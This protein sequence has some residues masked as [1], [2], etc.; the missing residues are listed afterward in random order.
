MARR[1]HHYRR[2]TRHYRRHRRGTTGGITHRI[3]AWM[4]GATRKPITKVVAPGIG[5]AA[6][7]QLLFTPL[8][9]WSWVQGVGTTIN[10]LN[11]NKGAT[12][13]QDLSNTAAFAGQQLMAN[14]FPAAMTGIGAAV[15]YKIGKWLG[16]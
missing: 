16:M 6:V 1:K 10:N 14:A 5:I 11:V 4:R 9:N 7:F 8:N 3:G 15:T 12:L 2:H 13:G